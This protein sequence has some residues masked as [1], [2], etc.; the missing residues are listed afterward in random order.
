MT[1]NPR[2][3]KYLTAIPL[4]AKFIC[5]FEKRKTLLLQNDKYGSYDLSTRSGLDNLERDSFLMAF[6][7][8]TMKELSSMTH[9]LDEMIC[10]IDFEDDTEKKGF[11]KNL[12]LLKKL[13]VLVKDNNGFFQNLKPDSSIFEQLKKCA[14]RNGNLE[15]VDRFNNLVRDIVSA[16]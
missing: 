11:I 1:F 15:V 7:S 4:F 3:Q 6:I 14:A 12:E 16:A 9:K 10:L 8:T 13:L 2:F 5:D